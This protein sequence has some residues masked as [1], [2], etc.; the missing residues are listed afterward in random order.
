MESFYLF[1]SDIYCTFAQIMACESLVGGYYTPV[2]IPQAISLLVNGVLLPSNMVQK[3]DNPSEC[4]SIFP[5]IL[6]MLRCQV[7]Y[8]TLLPSCYLTM[9]KRLPNWRTKFS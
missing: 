1:Y 6:L 3:Y 5:I 7:F 8:T 9:E 4:A 2:K